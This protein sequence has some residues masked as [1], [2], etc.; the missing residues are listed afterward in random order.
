MRIVRGTA[1]VLCPN[2][3]ANVKNATNNVEEILLG[4]DE[5]VIGDS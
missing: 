1:A 2:F 3:I 4:G 5:M